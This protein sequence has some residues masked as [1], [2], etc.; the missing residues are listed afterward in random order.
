[1]FVNLTFTDVLIQTNKNATLRYLIMD[2]LLCSE[3]RS[4]VGD[5]VSVCERSLSEDY[6]CLEIVSPESVREKKEAQN[7]HIWSIKLLFMAI[8]HF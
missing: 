6:C 2:N 7:M 1:M 5:T 4:V 3:E 8:L